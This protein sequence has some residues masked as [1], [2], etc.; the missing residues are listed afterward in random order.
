[1][2][3]FSAVLLS[4]AFATMGHADGA[5]SNWVQAEL[6]RAA[7]ADGIG[8]KVF[9]QT[10]QGLEPDLELPG[11]EGQGT[12]GAQQAEFASAS[13]YF[14]NQILKSTTAIGIEKAAQH[15]AL[16][17]RLEARFGVAGHVLLGIWGRE[18]AFGRAPL[19]NDAVQVLATRAFYGPRK[20][21]Y[22]QE[23]LAALHLIDNGIVPRG[24]LRAS[25]GGAVG[26]PQFMPSN[27]ASFAKDGDGDGRIDL[28][29]SP[30]DS[31]ASIASFLIAHGWTKGRDWGF[32]V[33]VPQ[34]VGCEFEGLDRARTIADWQAMGVRRA[35][36]RPFPTHETDGLAALMMPAGRNGPA[37]LVTPNFYVLKAYNN[38]DLYAL[39][40]GHLGDRIA[41]GLGDFF[42]GWAA[43]SEVSRNDIRTIQRALIDKGY[44][45]GGQDGLVG[46]KTRRSIGQWQ[47]SQ[48][49]AVTCYPS[50]ALVRRLR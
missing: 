36:G 28:V 5:F 26:Q 13:R 15:K 20:G 18:S 2:R 34:A 9:Y 38:S 6:R 10:M 11:L 17:N 21:Y 22:R 8:A 7:L 14:G 23:L 43:H 27:I 31:L 44:D 4:V 29:G 49:Q 37:F 32:E 50:R 25:W 24:G 40:V 46:F 30:E 48:G 41:F 16:L 3:L 35:N 47:R 42:G 1:M 33:L 45:V 19:R 39:F 12:E